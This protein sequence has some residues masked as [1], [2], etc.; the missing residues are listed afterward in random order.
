M[1]RQENETFR[2]Y[3]WVFLS[4]KLR[5]NSCQKFL[6]RFESGDWENQDKTFTLFSSS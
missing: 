1:L 4:L 3:F 6:I 2:L 5:S